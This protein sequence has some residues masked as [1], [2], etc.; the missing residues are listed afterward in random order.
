VVDGRDRVACALAAAAYLGDR[1]VI[2]WDDA[3]RDRY[4]DGFAELAAAGW[5]RVDFHGP[6][7]LSWSEHATAILYR[8][9]AN[10]LG[11]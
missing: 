1:G 6:K 9:G 5:A 7:P 4:R 10:V 2:V 8:R 3:T 11:L